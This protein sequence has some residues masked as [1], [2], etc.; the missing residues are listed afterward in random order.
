ME[1]KEYGCRE[2]VE[3]QDDDS[4]IDKCWV[5]KYKGD[6][7]K[8]LIRDGSYKK[9]RGPLM[10]SMKASFT[11]PEHTHGQWEQLGEYQF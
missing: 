8:W 3:E 2:E 6:S 11:Y 10:S 4:I 9:Q 1:N 7:R 5:A